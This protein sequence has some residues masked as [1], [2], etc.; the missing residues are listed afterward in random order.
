MTDIIKRI[1]IE[2]NTINDDIFIDESFID[3]SIKKHH[4]FLIPIMQDIQERYRY[5]PEG[6]LIKIAEKLQ[7]PLREV[8]G[9]ATF[10][11]SFSLFPKGEYIITVCLGTACYIRGGS[12][13]VDLLIKEL[14]I[15]PE[16]TTKD[17]KFT[18]E[19]VNCLGCC[20]IGPMVQIN[21]EFYR[22]MTP[23]KTIELIRTI[24][25]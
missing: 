22:E 6:Y 9:V 10:Y 1:E 24:K 21:N 13:I 8:Y 25:S 3:E 11:Q 20:A 2:D 19:T 18:L 16:E 7:I 14:K 4:N 15:N 5:L 17:K 12:K 23:E